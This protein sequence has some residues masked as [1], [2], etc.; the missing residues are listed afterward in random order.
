MTDVAKVIAISK[1]TLCRPIYMELSKKMDLENGK[2]VRVV[3]PIYGTREAAVSWFN[4][5]I[6]YYKQTLNMNGFTLGPC[7]LYW[8]RAAN[9]DGFIGIQVDD[10][11]C[12]VTLVFAAEK[13]RSSLEFPS[14]DQIEIEGKPE[15]FKG[16][17]IYVCDGVEN[18]VINQSE[19]INNIRKIKISENT[20]NDLFC[21]MRAQ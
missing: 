8:I 9:L 5:Y 11:I 4:T 2:I 19:Y 14:K 20:T 1:T 16:V 21:S 3:C 6:N 7:R 10:N 12:A 13:E 17:K 18:I 15:N